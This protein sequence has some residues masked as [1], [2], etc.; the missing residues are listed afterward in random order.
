MGQTSG[1]SP[2]KDEFAS[3]EHHVRIHNHGVVAR[4]AV[5]LALDSAT[6]DAAKAAYRGN[7]CGRYQVVTTCQQQLSATLLTLRRGGGMKLVK[8]NK[9]TTGNRVS[10]DGILL[11]ILKVS[12]SAHE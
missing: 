8:P 3:D 1:R 10:I 2:H 5:I 6:T 9:P 12:S 11:E 4:S 7:G